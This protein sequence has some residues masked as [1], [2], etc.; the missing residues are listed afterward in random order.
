M[1]LQTLV[2]FP[3][4]GFSFREVCFKT[5]F[6]FLLYFLKYYIRILSKELNL[7]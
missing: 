6:A 2:L 4:M 5:I 1:S 3:K 7:I